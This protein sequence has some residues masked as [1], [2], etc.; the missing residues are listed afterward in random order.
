MAAASLRERAIRLLAR[1]DHSHSE[2]ARKLADYGGTPEDIEETLSRM[3][4]LGL[5]DDRRFAA[6]WVRGKARGRGA[7]RLRHDLMQ[8][9]VSR[10][11]IEEALLAET[12]GSELERA[13]GL[14]RSRYGSV[15]AD[16]REWARQARFLQSR[17]FS[18]DVIRTLLKE[19]PDEF[20]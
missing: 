6:A 15:P 14:W 1:R 4:E 7:A 11:I 5:L 18:A 2:L 8:R 20:A 3:V 9:G 12:P 13:R 19:N 17:G 16:R 10:D